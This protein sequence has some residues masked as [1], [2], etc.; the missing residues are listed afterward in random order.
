MSK[1]AMLS[2]I[3]AEQGW[4]FIEQSACSEITFGEDTLQAFPPKGNRPSF[5]SI[6]LMDQADIH[7][8]QYSFFARAQLARVKYHLSQLVLQEN[9]LCVVQILPDH[10]DLVLYNFIERFLNE[11]DFWKVNLKH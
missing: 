1:L 5:L 3:A 8:D 2:K 9:Q 10:S 7:P 6:K 11:V 4:E